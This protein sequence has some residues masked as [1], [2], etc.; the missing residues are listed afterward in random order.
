[1]EKI[2][3]PIQARS[4]DLK[5]ALA[6]KEISSSQ[7]KLL[8]SVFNIHGIGITFF[9]ED[10]KMQSWIEN[11]LSSYGILK[12]ANPEDS[13]QNLKVSWQ[14]PVCADEWNED[15]NPNLEIIKLEKGEVAIQRD[16]LGILKSEK[17]VSIFLQPLL[18]DG[19]YNSLRWI[20]P[21]FL[22]SKNA[23]MMHS[24]CL[25]SQSGEAHLFLGPSGVG[26]TTTVSRAENRLILGDDMILITLENNRAFAETPVLGQNPKFK[27]AAGKK[28]P[29]A[30]FYFLEQSG[31]L[32]K[33][34]I[35]G[36]SALKH[37]LLSLMYPTWESV[38]ET[39]A[40]QLTNLAKN[41]L[42]LVPSWKLQLDLNT[43]FLGVIDG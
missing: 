32:R 5:K 21:R 3:S 25:V 35:A 12:L 15:P 42:D 8:S 6:K 1:M 36:L 31:E 33:I 7:T 16:F 40:T 43:P 24:S 30:G 39:E 26:K 13:N 37:F 20:L 2:N 18:D 10:S 19:F 41:F 4:R 27:G 34:P 23:L 11:I 38:S 9:Y 22:L 28:H 17:N 14:S 29:L